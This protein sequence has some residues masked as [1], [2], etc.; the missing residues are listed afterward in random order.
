MAVSFENDV[1]PLFTS[2]DISHMKDQDVYLDQY[3]WMSTPDNAN[4]V[5]SA[6]APP[7]GFMPIDERGTYVPWPQS[8][9]DTFKA[10]MDGGYQP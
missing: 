7:N 1:L 9:V 10:W 4:T 3:K 6:V 5:Y 8:K 2:D